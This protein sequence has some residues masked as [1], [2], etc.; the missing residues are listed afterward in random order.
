[1]ARI[2]IYMD[3][4]IIQGIASD[5]P[6]EIY[7]ADYDID[8]VES[9]HPHLMKFEGDECLLFPFDPAIDAGSVNLAHKT[10]T[11]T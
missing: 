1:M 8:G 9:D 2:L 5:E 4:G 10:F 3:G 7:I 6:V 11:A